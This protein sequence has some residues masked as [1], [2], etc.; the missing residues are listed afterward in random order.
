MRKVMDYIVFIILLL[1]IYFYRVNI[2][3]YAVKLYNNISGNTIKLNEYSKNINYLGF[4]KTDDFIPDNKQELINL[5]YTILDDGLDEYMFYCNYEECNND[6]DDIA[7]NGLLQ[8]INNYVH[9]FNS[10][11]IFNYKFI[12]NVATIN[13]D[14]SYDLMEIAGINMKMNTIERNIISDNMS[15]YDKI[16]A[17]HDYII[18]NTSYDKTD[19]DQLSRSSHKAYNV[20]IYGNGVCSGYT[21]AL[22]IFLY[23]HGYNGV[24]VSNNIHSW[25][26]ILLDKPYHID[27]TWD[28]PV[29]TSGTEVLTHDY[30]MITT[31]ELHSKDTET[32]SFDYNLYLE[33]K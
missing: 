19:E 17:F 26:V 14:H 25:N 30:F 32:H 23:R 1:L 21:D 20:L 29:T 11:N 3:I 2:T 15:D 4:S 24:T 6:L 12:L 27:M 33:L 28:D 16:K 5:I 7:E 8:V 10:F 18:N 31:S 22:A 9:P 13:I